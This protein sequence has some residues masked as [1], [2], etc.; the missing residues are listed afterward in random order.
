MICF[1]MFHGKDKGRWGG[2][3]Y[4]FQTRRIE[5]NIEDGRPFKCRMPMFTVSSDVKNNKEGL[6]L[7]FTI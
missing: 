7:V 4:K 3:K 2:N 1:W 5:E 6:K